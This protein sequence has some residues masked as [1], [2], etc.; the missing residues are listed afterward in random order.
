MLGVGQG[1]LEL[2]FKEDLGNTSV[3]ITESWSSLVCRGP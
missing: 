1:T 3:L 2:H